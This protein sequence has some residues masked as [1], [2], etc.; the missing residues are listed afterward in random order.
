MTSPGVPRGSCFGFAVESSVPLLDLRE[1][2]T[3]LPALVIRE[4]DADAAAATPNGALIAEW[5][6]SP[7]IPWPGRL[8]R[9]GTGWD[10]QI[11]GAGWFRID[12]GA[13]VITVPPT[14]D[15][16]RREERLWSVPAILCMLARGDLPL[17]AAAVE[18]DGQAV[19][20]AGPRGSGKS[21]LAAGLVRAGHRLL[22]E[23][24]V[25]LRPGMNEMLPGPAMLRL[26]RD[27][28]AW[29]DVPGATVAGHVDERVHLVLDAQS[30]GDGA[31]RPVAGIV[32]LAESRTGDAGMPIEATTAVAALWSLASQLPGRDGVAQR[33]ELVVDVA[34]A[35]PA[36]RLGSGAGP[37]GLAS[38]VAAVE[39]LARALSRSS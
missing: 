2:A 32:V 10:L 25:G 21:T 16:L 7:A 34:R 23:D 28:A 31:A 30:R 8:H 11:D 4:A 6:A 13:G 1:L 33:F 29:L 18:I 14:T 20:L 27:V 36:F 12:P 5:A 19:I 17:H 39:A 15:P 35:V 3:D 38:T 24:V 22:S 37:A 9:S 26:R